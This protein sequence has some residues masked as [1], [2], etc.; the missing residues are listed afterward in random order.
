[1]N[2]ILKRT[3]SFDKSLRKW[4][5]CIAEQDVIFSEESDGVGDIR[6]IPGQ[7]VQIQHDKTING[8]PM[9]WLGENFDECYDVAL[10]ESD[11]N[12]FF[13]EFDIK[14]L[15]EKMTREEYQ[16]IF[17][18]SD[19]E[20]KHSDEEIYL[21]FYDDYYSLAGERMLESAIDGR[22]YIFKEKVNE[23]APEIVY[24]I[25]MQNHFEKYTISDWIRDTIKNFPGEYII[26]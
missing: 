20:M 6:V 7:I 8:W 25:M 1:M 2:N 12:E 4:Y 5:H 11:F 3:W 23:M 15:E 24:H 10:P 13:E 22:G 16:T 21:G 26:D 17:E 19:E 14:T 9:I 18:L